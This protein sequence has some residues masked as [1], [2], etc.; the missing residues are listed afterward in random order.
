MFQKCFPGVPHPLPGKINTPGALVNRVLLEYS[1]HVCKIEPGVGLDEGA[2]GI[3]FS[4]Y[5]LL[6]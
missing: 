1:L 4:K 3:H 6:E 5:I 2:M